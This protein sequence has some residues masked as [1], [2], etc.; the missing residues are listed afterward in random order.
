MNKIIHCKALLNCS[1][2]RA[3]CLF[4]K[5]EEIITWLTEKSEIEPWV[6]GKYELF[7]DKNDNENN[8]TLG[9][10]VTAFELNKLL[11]FNWKGP[12][13][14]ADVM[15]VAKPLTHV[16]ITF[17]AEKENKTEI[18]LIHSGWGEGEKWEQA[19]LWF[20]KVWKQSFLR[21]ENLF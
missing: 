14:Y 8:S 20:E 6:G 16:C 5:N 4:I 21:L 15:N 7:W 3:F 12:V 18:H 10:K 1:S 13:Q 19:R 11:C 9:C 17:F 2:E